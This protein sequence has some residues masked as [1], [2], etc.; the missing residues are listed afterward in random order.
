MAYTLV[1]GLVADGD[2]PHGWFFTAKIRQRQVSPFGWRNVRATTEQPSGRVGSALL[3]GRA[4]PCVLCGRRVVPDHDE[5]F[6]QV[7]SLPGYRVAVVRG[8]VRSAGGAGAPGK[9]R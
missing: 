3:L 7:I 6:A 2:R 1:R 5:Q 8:F 4:V 9:M